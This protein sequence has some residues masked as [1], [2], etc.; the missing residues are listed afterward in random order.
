MFNGIGKPALLQ[1]LGCSNRPGLSILSVSG[2]RESTR[3]KWPEQAAARTP[4]SGPV[5]TAGLTVSHA[6]TA[7]HHKRGPEPVDNYSP[8]LGFSE[9][10]NRFEV[11]PKGRFPLWGWRFRPHM[12]G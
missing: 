4:R 2:P 9:E 11:L 5:G 3:L 12:E 8:T 1:R 7:S 10:F 6:R